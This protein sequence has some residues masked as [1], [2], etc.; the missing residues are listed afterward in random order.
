MTAKAQAETALRSMKGSLRSWLSY[1][2]Q[3]DEYVSGKRPAPML[4]RAP[5]AAPL[6][7]KVIAQTLTRERAKVEQDL[8]ETLYALLTECGVDAANLPTP[9]VV[10][11]PNSAAKLAEI[12]IA[13]QCPSDVSSP[14]AQGFIWF[15]VIPVAGIVLLLS[16]MIKSKAEV[17]KEAERM[18]CIESGACTDYGFWLKI[19]SITVVGWIAWDKFGVR[20]RVK[21]L[22]KK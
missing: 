6:P 4:F 19:A 18:R 13:G 2:K 10:T 8:A 12:A 1:R 9:S 17:A 7:P 20:E 21:G 16:Q 15:I 22:L 5:G 3:M 14:Q 11:D